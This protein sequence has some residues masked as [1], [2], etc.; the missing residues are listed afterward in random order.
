MLAFIQRVLEAEDEL[1]LA[2][3]RVLISAGGTREPL[4][5]VRY[6]ANRSTGR[7][8]CALAEAA[9][10]AGASVTLVA[11]NIDKA[12]IPPR[13]RVVQAPDARALAGQMLRL[14]PEFDL[15]IMSAAVADYRPESTA[16]AKIK[17][18]GE[19]GYTLRLVQNPDVLAALV[20]AKPSG[21]T[22][23]GFAAETGD[24]RS[25]AQLAEEKLARK[26]CDYLVANRVGN[27]AG[28]GDVDTAVTVL[29]LGADA[30]A[31]PTFSGTKSQIAPR[32]LRY[33][34]TG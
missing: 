23:V 12:L 21:Q 4:D 13:V 22:I 30:A 8:G 14:Q 28:F 24:H 1:R 7:I 6:L 27:A 33:V 5:P 15:V 34:T 25:V 17:K 20:A 2:G 32:I 26:G 11:A 19:D 29:K 16:E 9:V 18:N 31:A 3:L 10:R